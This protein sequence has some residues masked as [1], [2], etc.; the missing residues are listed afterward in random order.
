L[1]DAFP[2]TGEI[3]IPLT[4]ERK[5]LPQKIERGSEIMS[6]RQSKVAIGYKTDVCINDACDAEKAS[7]VNAF[8]VF[9]EMLGGGP[10]S[11]LFSN[12]REKMGLCYYCS[13]SYS[14]Y[15]GVMMIHSGVDDANVEIVEKKIDDEIQ[16]IRDGEFSDK[17]L[18]SAKLAL[19]SGYEQIFD[20]TAAIEN[21]YLGRGLTMPGVTVDDVIKNIM[22]VTSE[23]VIKITS[24]VA[25]GSVFAV[26]GRG[27]LDD[28]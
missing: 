17:E 3:S 5:H 21:F 19:K 8:Q 23:D 14:P 18:R 27:D 28:E 2:P 15:S 20:S 13:S 25:K 6:F 11:K 9:C 10:T 4:V 26:R 7:D 16:A 24:R 1:I 12:V 22:N